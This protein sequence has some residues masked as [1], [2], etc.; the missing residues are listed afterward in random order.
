MHVDRQDVI[1]RIHYIEGHLGGIAKMIEG[2]ANCIEV[3]RQT[4][5]VRKAIERLEISSLRI[6]WLLASIRLSGTGT[7]KF[8]LQN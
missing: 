5:A 4:Y 8:S 2:D 1:K 6:I 3:L 7:K